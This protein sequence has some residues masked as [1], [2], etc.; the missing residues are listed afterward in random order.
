MVFDLGK[1][2]AHSS[3]SG[4]RNAHDYRNPEAKAG[5]SDEKSESINNLTLL[6]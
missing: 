4:G 5:L 3:K 2:T 1:E 6:P